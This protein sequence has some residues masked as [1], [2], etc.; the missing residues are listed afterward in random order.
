MT[1]N[2]EHG[3]LNIESFFPIFG[4][5]E[6]H[7]LV[8]N[9]HGEMMSSSSAGTSEENNKESVTVMNAEPKFLPQLFKIHEAFPKLRIVLEHVSTRDAIEAVRQCGS[10]V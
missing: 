9:I 7:N 8:L 4:A 5:M 3:V 2:S 6:K 10:T 1:T